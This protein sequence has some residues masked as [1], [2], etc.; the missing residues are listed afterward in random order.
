[1]LFPS[2]SLIFQ[3]CLYITIPDL[4][5]MSISYRSFWYSKQAKAAS[6]T[7]RTAVQGCTGVISA[8]S[9]PFPW[10]EPGAGKRWCT[11]V[12]DGIH[13]CKWAGWTAAVIWCPCGWL[14]SGLAAGTAWVYSKIMDLVTRSSV[15]LW[16]D[17]RPQAGE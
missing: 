5:Q 4:W 8:Q 2:C 16:A 6:S 10:Q 12:G 15:L 14:R 3:E 11:S 17:H 1:M 13:T 7:W 9:F